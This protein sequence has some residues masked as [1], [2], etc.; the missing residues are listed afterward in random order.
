MKSIL[1]IL[2]AVISNSI[3]ASDQLNTLEISKIEGGVYLHTSYRNIEGFGMV[4]S[5]GIIVV[6]NNNVYVIDTPWSE[7]DTQLLLQWVEKEGFT[8]KAS[9]STH[10][11]DDRAAGIG[12][13]NSNS[14]P[15]YAS[16]LTNQFLHDSGKPVA[17]KTFN[18]NTFS[19]LEGRIEVFYPGPGHTIDNVVVWLPEKKILFAGCLVRSLGWNNLGNILDADIENWASSVRRIKSEYP[20][21]SMVIPGHGEIGDDKILDHTIELAERAFS[22]LTQQTA[23]DGVDL[24]FLKDLSK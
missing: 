8:L 3:V 19:L 24:G 13:M 14:I 4:D 5:H 10:S 22:K 11:H 1:F 9:L 2:A 15:S 6:D 17:S 7:A 21:I 20:D 18:S 16:K 12:L 23:G